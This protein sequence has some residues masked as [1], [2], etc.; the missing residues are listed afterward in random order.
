ME[1]VGVDELTRGTRCA[2]DLVGRDNSGFTVK[3]LIRI[4]KMGGHWCPSSWLSRSIKISRTQFKLL[5]CFS[6]NHVTILSTS[7]YL[8]IVFRVEFRRHAL[9]DVLVGRDVQGEVPEDAVE[10]VGGFQMRWVDH[11]VATL[12]VFLQPRTL[13][14]RV[15]EDEVGQWQHP[16][17]L[18]HHH[19]QLG[20]VIH[21]VLLVVLT[22]THTIISL[23]VSQCPLEPAMS[24][25]IVHASCFSH[26]CILFVFFAVTLQMRMSH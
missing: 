20:H 24:V 12:W 22:T 23:V 8:E 3:G 11:V 7:R 5:V 13:I 10:E 17:L 21:R 4:Q 19:H 18:F 16:P 15:V 9:V 14:G 26:T 6:M 1:Q 25:H 2:I